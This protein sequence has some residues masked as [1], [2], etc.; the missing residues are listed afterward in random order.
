MYL[1]GIDIG[2]TKCAA[3]LAKSAFTPA[4]VSEGIVDRAEIPTQ[5]G[6]KSPD[7]ILEELASLIEKLCERN[8][9]TTYDIAKIG[10]SC[11][12]PLDSEKGIIK[13]P[14]NLPD[15]DDVHIKDFFEKRFFVPVFLQ[16]DAN[17][18]ALAEY[19]FGAGRGYKNIIFL[20]CGTGMGAGIIINGN[21]YTGRN[22]MAGEV[23]HIRLSEDGPFGYGKHGSFE[24]Y[25]SGSGIANL[26]AD[27]LKEWTDKGKTSQLSDILKNGALSA[28]D[29][30]DAMYSGDELAKKV[31]AT[32]AEYLGKGVGILV[33][34]LNPEIVIIGSIFTRNA[35]F[36]LP[37][38]TKTVR[39]EALAS[40]VHEL[41]I[42]PSQLGE[43]IGDYAAIG[44]IA[45]GLE[46]KDDDENI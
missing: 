14:P 23:G 6:E 10:I 28:K 19:R 1:I 2:G 34:I 30:F 38:V 45:D 11:G 44:I 43:S 36:Y 17:A 33:D 35:D 24:G 37:I 13:S 18:C 26:A 15:W 41:K 16:N 7:T 46:L 3:V 25:C 39:R 42:V 31:A 4:L 40:S 21:L 27:M 9:I 32:S 29:V 12:S 22:D 20:T 5:A 8:F